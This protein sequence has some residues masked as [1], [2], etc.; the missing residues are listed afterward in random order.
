MDNFNLDFSS[1]DPDTKALKN[2]ML[3][4]GLHPKTV[5]FIRE[6]IGLQS[7]ICN[8]FTNIDSSKIQSYILITGI[9]DRHSQVPK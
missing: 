2:I 8:W 6:F 3:T 1:N 7:S 4:F 9:S 5:S